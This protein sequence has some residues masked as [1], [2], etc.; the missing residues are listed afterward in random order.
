MKLS[1]EDDTEAT[2]TEATDAKATDTE[3]TDTEA[4]ETE[5]CYE[6]STENDAND[7]EGNGG[8]LTFYEDIEMHENF[9]ERDE[10][11]F[12]D[13]EERPSVEVAPVVYHE[14]KM[15]VWI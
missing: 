4:T 13:I 12:E 10:H 8:V 9:T 7:N 3:G 6:D 11:V 14:P 2:D 5:G 1:E 15:M